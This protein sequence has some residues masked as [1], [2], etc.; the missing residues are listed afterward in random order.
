MACELGMWNVGHEG[1]PLRCTW[2]VSWAPRRTH[3]H[4]SGKGYSASQGR[5]W[6]AASP[7]YGGRRGQN[8]GGGDGGGDGVW[9]SDGGHGGVSGVPGCEGA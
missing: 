5:T 2:S 3:P 8:M 4:T 6:A 1:K 9:G 7:G